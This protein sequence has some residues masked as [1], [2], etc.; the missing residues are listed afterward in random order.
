MVKLFPT[1]GL[2]PDCLSSPR[3]NP[4]K[5]LSIALLEAEFLGFTT[6]NGR[7]SVSMKRREFTVKRMKKKLRDL[8]MAAML[9]NAENQEV[10]YRQRT[11]IALF[12]QKGVRDNGTWRRSPC[13]VLYTHTHII[14]LWD[15]DSLTG[16]FGLANSIQTN[17]RGETSKG[18]PRKQRGSFFILRIQRNAY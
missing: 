8:S 9:I 16:I 17:V 12:V 2:G 6:L 10:L 15:E 13:A 11:D 14:S 4:S 3:D 1:P 5:K 7:A 18:V